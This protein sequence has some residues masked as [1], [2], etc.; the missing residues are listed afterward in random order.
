[1]LEGAEGEEGGGKGRKGGG[2][3]QCADGAERPVPEDAVRKRG[4]ISLPATANVIQNIRSRITPT[5]EI[6]GGLKG[7]EG[8]DQR[9]VRKRKAKAVYLHSRRRD[10]V[11]PSSLDSLRGAR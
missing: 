3:F 9:G 11:T 5:A 7:E 1:M 6:Q 2:E 8:G 4:E 10:V